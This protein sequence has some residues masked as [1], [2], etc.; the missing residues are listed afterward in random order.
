MRALENNLSVGTF[1]LES[2]SL[3]I[4]VKSDIAKVKEAMKKD[5]ILKKYL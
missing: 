4:D 3:A 2:H 5:K 1:K